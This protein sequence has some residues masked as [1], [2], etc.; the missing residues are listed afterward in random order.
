MSTETAAPHAASPSS[1]SL[2]PAGLRWSAPLL[3]VGYGLGVGVHRAMSKARWAPLPTICI[4]NLTVGGTGKT[5]MAKYL[6][7]HLATLGRKPAVLMRGYKGQGSDEAREVEHALRD[8]PVPVIIGGDRYQSSLA[9]RDKGRDTV[10]LDDGFQHWALARDL[11]IVLIDATNPFGGGHL[12]PWGRLREPASGLQRAGAV[13]ITRADAVSPDELDALRAQIRTLSRT[14]TLSSA[15]HAPGA[16][17]SLTG[18]REV[19]PPEV[20]QGQTVAAVCG[21]G[22]PRAFEQTL[23]GLGANLKM[24]RALPDHAEFS[25]ATLE[26]ILSC[27]KSSGAKA[28]VVTEK[29]AMKIETLLAGIDAT[30]WALEVKLQFVTGQAEF[31]QAV[32]A[33][34]QQAAQRL[35]IQH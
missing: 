6:G 30:V 26:E 8:L 5:P 7:R 27:A 21:I 14:P 31:E 1:N 3:A 34:L 19:M 18:S 22:N 28:L 10:L 32:Q 35:K 20:L 12:V 13:V 17:R 16:L 25:R 29:D 9:A 2:L 33:G 23:L 11:D 4:G 24:F 15:K